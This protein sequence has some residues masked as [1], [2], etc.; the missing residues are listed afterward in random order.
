VIGFLSTN[1]AFRS[2]T[3][4]AGIKQIALEG[5]RIFSA[6]RRIPWAGDAGVTTCFIAISKGLAPEH[7]YLD[8]KEVGG[9][10]SHLLP[11]SIEYE[12][13]ELAENLGICF[14]GADI[15]G[16]G[17]LFWEDSPEYHGSWREAE[18]IEKAFPDE[19]EIIRYF[20]G[21]KELTSKP[22]H[23]PHRKV[24]DFTGLTK[25]EASSRYPHLF[26]IAEERVKPERDKLGGY[27]VAE[28]SRERWWLFGTATPA[29]N[30]AKKDLEHVIG[31]SRTSK[32]TCFSLLPAE[33]TFGDKLVI[34][35][36][37]NLLPALG[38]L[39]SSIHSFWA[40]FN[41][42]TREDRPVYSSTDCFGTFPAPF[43]G[44]WNF[45][46]TDETL[47]ATVS[48]TSQNLFRHRSDT[49]C[50]DEIGMTEFYNRF[51]DPS[52][53]VPDCLEARR[54]Q[55]EL[56]NSYLSLYGWPTIPQDQYGFAP[57]YVEFGNDCDTDVGAIQELLSGKLFYQDASEAVEFEQRWKLLAD[58]DAS[59]P[60]RYRWPDDVRDDVLA[61]LLA[62]NA[63]RYAEE[64]VMGLHGKGAKKAAG[65]A[66]TA[67]KRRGRPPK[68]AQ[69]SETGGQ[70][71]ENQQTEQRGLGL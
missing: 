46:C 51:H 3:R 21:G 16:E 18:E 65:P 36:A 6:N 14:R 33:Y 66:A 29:L 25:A 30:N 8:G 56:D 44:L 70:Q 10:N 23:M 71:T 53:E 49:L 37:R 63:E 64:V 42:A 54:L 20:L 22:R 47:L 43:T 12:P 19:K 11:D 13:R 45:P 15:Y 59:L 60:W 50:G 26:T 48:S 9:I 52:F 40:A 68:A 32:Y 55:V 4:E 28:N 2:D 38:L 41:G 34:V 62:L 5:G 39:S 17:F 69:A 58:T 27:S 24:I 1:N 7:I 35:C 61:R 31:I 67:G 57:E